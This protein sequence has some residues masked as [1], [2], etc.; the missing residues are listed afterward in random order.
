ML[1][2]TRRFLSLLCYKK[3]LVKNNLYMF[4]YEETSYNPWRVPCVLL[5]ALFLPGDGVLSFAVFKEVN[6]V[7][8]IICPK[9]ISH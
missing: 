3:S 6:C 2:P 9:S 7:Y 4:K 8:T 1:Q 5:W